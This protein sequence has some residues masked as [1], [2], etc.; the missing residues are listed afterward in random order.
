MVLVIMLARV[1]VPRQ[2]QPALELYRSRV[3]YACAHDGSLL[4]VWW[5]L[6]GEVWPRRG[7]CFASWCCG[8]GALYGQDSA[9]HNCMALGLGDFILLLR[10]EGISGFGLQ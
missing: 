5:D 4:S 6:A 1:L 10:V 2:V 7:F 9:V 3:A 8:R